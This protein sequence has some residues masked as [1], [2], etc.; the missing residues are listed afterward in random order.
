MSNANF[1]AL[2]DKQADQVEKPK[3]LPMGTFAWAILEHRFDESAKKKT[4][5]IEFTVSPRAALDDV[6][7]D[8]LAEVTNWQDKKMRLTF[9]LTDD[10]LFRLK[11]FMEHCGIDLTGRTIAEGIPETQ[12]AMFNGYVQHEPMQNNP[13][14]MFASISKTMP[15]E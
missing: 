3:P 14:E 2:L 15:A 12:G 13:E 8:L 1:A 6:D 9:Y 11:D 10:S 5:F 7:E 4:P